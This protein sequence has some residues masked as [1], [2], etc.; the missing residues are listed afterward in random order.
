MS[1]I[2]K[3]QKNFKKLLTFNLDCITINKVKNL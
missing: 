1:Q 3:N 2:N